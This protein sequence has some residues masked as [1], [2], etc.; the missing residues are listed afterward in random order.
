MKKA[1]VLFAHGARDAAWATPM[2]RIQENLAAKLPDICV[3]LA[4]LEFMVPDVATCVE[5][6]LAQGI[7]DITVLP[8]FIATGGH[9]KKDLPALADGLRAKHP[10]LNLKLTA[11]IG[12]V[13]DVQ[14]AIADYAAQL[15]NLDIA[16]TR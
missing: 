3:E 11:A 14:E 13:L 5:A 2:R 8:L 9:L 10:A 1:I 15:M 4:F 6:L 12:E 7:R 16:S